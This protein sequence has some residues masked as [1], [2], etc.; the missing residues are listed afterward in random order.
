MCRISH[1][2]YALSKEKE[3]INHA[4]PEPVVHSLQTAEMAA[5]S[6]LLTAVIA[7]RILLEHCRN[8]GHRCTLARQDRW[9][10][11]GMNQAVDAADPDGLILV[12]KRHIG[13]TDSVDCLNMQGSFE[14]GMNVAGLDLDSHCRQNREAVRDRMEFEGHNPLQWGFLCHT[15]HLECLNKL[16]SVGYLNDCCRAGFVDRS[17]FAHRDTHAL[18]RALS[19]RKGHVVRNYLTAPNRVGHTALTEVC[20]EQNVRLGLFA[21]SVTN[22]HNSHFERWNDFL[23]D[24]TGCTAR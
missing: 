21:H 6:L 20:P 18:L 14:V 17:R 3:H 13:H 10:K 12:S 22:Q 24:S 1:I 15:A 16:G 8:L 5:R 19:S 23:C 4:S 9:K 11:A 2:Q 7:G